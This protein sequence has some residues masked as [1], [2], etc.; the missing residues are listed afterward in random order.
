MS[1]SRPR[2]PSHATGAIALVLALAVALL[3]ASAAVAAPRE[4]FAQVESELMCVVCHEPLAEANAPEAIAERNYLRLLIAKGE[5]KRQIER[6]MVAAYTP[7]VLAN[8]PAHGF[9]VLVYVIPPVVLIV[10]IAV[11]AVTLPRWLG[12]RRISTASPAAPEASLDPAD[13]RRLD[14]ELGRFA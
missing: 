10:G 11:V 14:E 12:R 6:A 5:D 2:R 9:N 1:G 7:A 13:A 4:S 3:T 8:P